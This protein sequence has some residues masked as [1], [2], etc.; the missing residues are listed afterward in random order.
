MKQRSGSLEFGAYSPLKRTLQ[1]FC[2]SFHRAISL[3]CCAK[4]PFLQPALGASKETRVAL[5]E[6]QGR[7]WFMNSSIL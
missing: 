3:Y 4:R 6:N 7:C 2:D 5:S 1:L